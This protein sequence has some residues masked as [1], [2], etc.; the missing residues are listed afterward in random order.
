MR[1]LLRIALGLVLVIPVAL[2]L[3]SILGLEIGRTRYSRR[4]REAERARR[5]RARL[6]APEARPV[7]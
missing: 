3:L 1:V 6:G 5:A 2:V 4:A 7:L